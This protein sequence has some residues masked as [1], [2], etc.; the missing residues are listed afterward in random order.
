MDI[1]FVI[2]EFPN[3]PDNQTVYIELDDGGDFQGH[4]VCKLVVGEDGKYKLFKRVD[5]DMSIEAEGRDEAIKLACRELMKDW[6]TP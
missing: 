2:H 1:R 3:E 6:S 5:T 4:S